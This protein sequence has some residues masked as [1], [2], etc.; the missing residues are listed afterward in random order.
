VHLTALTQPVETV[1]NLLIHA[2]EQ[3]QFSIS[4][5]TCYGEFSGIGG[6]GPYW[7]QLFAKMSQTTGDI[8]A[9][10]HYNYEFCSAPPVIEI[11]EKDWFSPKP[12]GL[13]VPKPSGQTINVLHLSDW[14]LDPRYDI[15]SEAN[16]SESLCY[17]PYSTN[18]ALNTDYSSP[19]VPAS[20]FGYLYCDSPADLAISV[21]TEM[22]KF[23]NLND[24]SFSIFTGDIVSHDHDDQLSRAYVQY[25]EEVTYKTFKAHL[26]TIVSII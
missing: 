2:C 22:P 26:G 18:T 14:H 24:I 19:S 20:R 12:S 8:Q 23:V 5:A 9:W 3:F 4:A 16:C 7:A 15:G 25:E 11:N 13:N 21:F 6:T 1:T 17:R 10:C